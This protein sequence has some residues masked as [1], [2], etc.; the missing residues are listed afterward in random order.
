MTRIIREVFKKKKN[1]ILANKKDTKMYCICKKCSYV[2]VVSHKSRLTLG[3]VATEKMGRIESIYKNKMNNTQRH[4]TAFLQ[5]VLRFKHPFFIM[6]RETEREAQDLQTFCH[7]PRIKDV[8]PICRDIVF[9]CGLCS[10]RRC[11]PLTRPG[12]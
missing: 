5:C 6:R 1:S 10:K 9:R 7:W 12:I 3:S 2:F 4:F 8:G 11:S